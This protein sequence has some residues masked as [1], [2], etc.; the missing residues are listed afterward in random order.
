M[1]PTLLVSA[2]IA[3]APDAP[4][5]RF[6]HRPALELVVRVDASRLRLRNPSDVPELVIL[7]DRADGPSVTLTLA[8]HAE[9]EFSYATSALANFELTVVSRGADGVHVSPSLALG[10]LVACA[11]VRASCSVARSDHGHA[12]LWSGSRWVPIVSSSTHG[13][14]LPISGSNSS[15]AAHVPVITPSE[16]Q[17]GDLPPKLE[18]KPLPAV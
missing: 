17:R 14:P 3:C 11:D 1:L 12:W 18:K 13:E 8:P 4:H 16:G 10:A 5:A 7:A 6:D 9:L 15:P 2:A